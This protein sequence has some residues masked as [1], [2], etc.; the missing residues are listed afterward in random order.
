M[1]FS[2]NINLIIWKFKRVTRYLQWKSRYL[3]NI[4]RISRPIKIF[5]PDEQMFHFKSR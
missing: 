3:N 4:N 1:N 2:V 5:D